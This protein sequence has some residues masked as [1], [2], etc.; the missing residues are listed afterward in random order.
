[1]SLGDFADA[2][3][4]LRKAVDVEPSSLQ[5]YASL[6]RLLVKQKRTD[7]AL[8]EYQAAAKLRP[9]SVA[10][11]TMIGILLEEEHKPLEAQKQYE[12]TLAMD[13]HAG[14]AASNLASIYLSNGGNLDVALR[15][16]QTATSQL[17]NAPEASGTLG[18]VYY[19]KG[20]A[21]LAIAPLQ[22]SLAK[23]PDNPIYLG[24]LGMAF[25]KAG[26]K[27]KARE[28]LQRA[29]T[30]GSDFPDAKEARDTLST[31]TGRTSG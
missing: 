27:D 21:N 19:R 5:A 3:H 2:E 10:V 11:A 4:C 28:M 14:V 18:W 12:K 23:E 22:E 1:M 15:L 20:L 17:P 8:T 31:L 7:E 25:A 9:T 6:A 13:S 30:H 29:F 26:Q 16:A 24:H